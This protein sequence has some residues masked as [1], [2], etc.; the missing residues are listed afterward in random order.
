MNIA[1]KPSVDP[2]REEE[3]HLARNLSNRHLQLIAIGGA[4]GT[5]LFMGSGKTISLA[6]PSILLVYA[7]IGFMLFF[8]MRALGEILLSNLEYRSFADFAGD[9]LGPWAQF[10]TGWTYWLCWI[11]TG[12]A[13]VVA[14]SGYVSFWFPE[15][16]LWIPA[17][18]LI[19]T[20]LALNL[21]TVRNF[22][23]IEFWFALIKIVAIVGLIIAGV[24][25]L[26]TGF[27]LP[28]GSQ[29]S[30]AHLWN[31]GGFFP[32]GFLGF[33]AGFQIAVF[34]FVGI[35]LVGTAAAETKDPERNLPKAINSIPIRV[36]LFYLG[37]L[38]VIITVIPWDQ[39]D[40]NSSPFVAMFSLA[41]LG[42]AAHVV[43]FVVLTSATSSA[44]SGIYS[45]SRM[46]YG[47]ATSKLAPKALAKLNKRQVPVNSLFFSCVFLLAGVVLLYAGQSIIEAFTIVTTISALL[48][49]FIW[50]II[51]ASYL[52]YRRKRPDLHEKS[53][54]KM[55]GGRA[56]V[57]MVFAFFAFILWALAQEP[58]TAAALKITPLWFVLLAVAYLVMKSRRSQG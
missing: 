18:G 33:V 35:E 28:N 50:S 2:H 17:L 1:S 15:L 21:P 13:D 25:M 14:V 16:A 9:Y 51:L 38:F 12:V 52:Q 31:H 26:S 29:A 23:E 4:I 5:G 47:L 34:A 55:P 32:N 37:A 39:V 11:V 42:I 41:G 56:A 27:T 19:F 57:V 46:I 58:D 45:T 22:G 48:F 6:G 8:V 40:P 53:T 43:N 36:V 54:F 24:Y 20:L 10:F 3:P 49:I 44:N 30:V 7:V